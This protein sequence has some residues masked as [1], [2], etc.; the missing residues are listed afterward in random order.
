ME[1]QFTRRG[2]AAIFAVVVCLLLGAVGS[3][4]LGRFLLH[5]RIIGDSQLSVFPAY[6]VLAGLIAGGVCCAVILIGVSRSTRS[7]TR[8]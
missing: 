4:L 7:N 8:D 6:G 5:K 2:L 1:Q 3:L